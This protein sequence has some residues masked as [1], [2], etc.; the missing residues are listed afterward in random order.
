MG[1]ALLLGAVG[2]TRGAAAGFK[3]RVVNLQIRG[4]KLHFERVQAAQTVVIR[5]VVEDG[6]L[7][8]GGV[9]VKAIVRRLRGNRNEEGYPRLGAHVRKVVCD[10]VDKG[11]RGCGGRIVVGLVEQEH[12]WLIVIDDARDRLRLGARVAG[13]GAQV[14]VNV[15]LHHPDLLGG[16]RLGPEKQQAA[17]QLAG[18]LLY[19]GTT[20]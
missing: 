12:V 20:I 7:A 19:G 15:P 2:G 10:P 14:A 3:V 13:E 1:L 17:G 18:S 4:G 9:G 8:D 5:S 16:Q 6:I 11:G